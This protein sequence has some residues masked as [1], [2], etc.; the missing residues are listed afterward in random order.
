M[1][2]PEEHKKLLLGLG[3]KEEEFDLFDGKSLKYEY[4]DEKGVRIYDPSYKTSCSVY[5]EVGGWS[6]WS[7]E[8]DDFMEQLFPDGLP[9]RVS[10]KE[11]TLSEEEIEKLRQ[12]REEKQN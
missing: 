7:G 3:V 8:E 6:S 2:I 1:D 12:K 4:D 10:D 9:E 5:I 11:V